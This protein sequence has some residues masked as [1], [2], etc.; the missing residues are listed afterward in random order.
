MVE[1]IVMPKVDSGVYY[2][3]YDFAIDKDPY[4]V[5]KRMRNERPL[6]YNQKHDFYALSRYEDVERCSKDWR[7]YSSAK[8]TVLE[9]RT[10]VDRADR[11][12]AGRKAARTRRANAKKRSAAA[13]KGARK[14][15]KA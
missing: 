12:T 9:L 8:G 2:D 10:H 4:P 6:Y 5:W 3:P 1:T 7:R 15:A 14:R 11:K 13:K